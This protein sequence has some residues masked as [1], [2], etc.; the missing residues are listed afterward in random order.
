M[1]KKIFE[2]ISLERENRRLLE[3]KKEFSKQQT[4]LLFEKY[5]AHL[6]T[7]EHENSK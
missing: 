4:E 7:K 5:K 3:L 6:K 1:L 2:W